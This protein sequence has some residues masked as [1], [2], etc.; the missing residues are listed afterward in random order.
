MTNLTV[1]DMSATFPAK[2]LL[3]ELHTKLIPNTFPESVSYPP[4][5][6][7]L[8]VFI[9]WY[10]L[11]FIGWYFGWYYCVSVANF[12]SWRELLF[13]DFAGLFFWKKNAGSHSKRGL[14]PPFW[15]KWGSH[16][17]CNTEKY[18][19]SFPS[20][21]VGIYRRNTNRYQPKYRRWYVTLASTGFYFRNSTIG[22][23]GS[24]LPG[25]TPGGFLPEKIF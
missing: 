1:A 23:I 14:S 10:C 4:P 15:G 13:K 16:Q 7:V 5:R 20:V 25:P 3:L 11:V 9:G 21:S 24:F 8:S 6:L 19:P 17:I 22:I 12:L 2:L 18:Q